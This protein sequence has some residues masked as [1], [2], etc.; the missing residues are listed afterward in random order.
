MNT[1]LKN[2]FLEELE[3]MYDA[4]Q[5]ITQALPKL[6]EAATCNQ[7]K[8]AL[9]SHLQETEGQ[10]EKLEN[11]FKAFDA[12]A[13]GQKCQAMAGLLAEG[14]ALVK[15]NKKSPAIN[16]AIISAAQKVEHYEIA[17]YGC[18]KAWAGILGNNEAVT[19]LE[20]ILEEEKAADHALNALSEAKN[21]E[22]FQEARP[23]TLAQ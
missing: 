23:G 15:K 16:A 13:A 22:A 9:Q 8:S 19:L 17:S 3:D 12:E 14:D 18:L 20:E 10:I 11:V 7:L 1:T 6:I 4:E 5:R 2:L 21:K